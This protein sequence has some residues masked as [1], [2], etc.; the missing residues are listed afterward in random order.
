MPYMLRCYHWLNFIINLSRNTYCIDKLMFCTILVFLIIRDQLVILQLLVSIF[1]IQGK[2]IGTCTCVG[3]TLVYVQ[4]NTRIVWR[5]NF[6][7]RLNFLI[8]GRCGCSCIN[9]CHVYRNK[10]DVFMDILRMEISRITIVFYNTN[11]L[12][13]IYRNITRPLIV[14]S[15]AHIPL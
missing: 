2:F 3:Q 6:C 7:T 11:N 9:S 1:F 14:H 10:M 4:Y 12:C 15:A 8:T 13:W 5:I